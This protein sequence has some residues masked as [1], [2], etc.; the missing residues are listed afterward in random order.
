MRI[1]VLV[2]FFLVSISSFFYLH[3][4]NFD[5]IYEAIDIIYDQQP[6][7][8]L[9]VNAKIDS[10][11]PIIEDQYKKDILVAVSNYIDDKFKKGNYYH[12]EVSRKTLT[13]VRIIDEQSFTDQEAEDSLRQILSNPDLSDIDKDYIEYSLLEAQASI[14][15]NHQN[16]QEA[17]SITIEYFSDNGGYDNDKLEFIARNVDYA[18]FAFFTQLV[19]WVNP[20]G[21]NKIISYRANFFGDESNTA[22]NVV[23][24]KWYDW[25]DCE[26]LYI[27][28]FNIDLI[29]EK[30]CKVVNWD[31]EEQDLADV[32]K[33]DNNL[34]NLSDRWNYYSYVS[35]LDS[36][37]DQMQE[38]KKELWAKILAYDKNYINGYFLM[39]SFYSYKSD[40]ENYAIYFEMMKENYVWDNERKEKVFWITHPNCSQ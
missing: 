19:S 39:L 26:G 35:W 28:D 12:Q 7:K 13:S 8:L 3:A 4:T 23:R 16:F 11:L 10:L 6:E 1:I 27:K 15:L 18:S 31:F 29:D 17:K 9:R 25:L 38:N 14:L 30:L 2:L 33:L 34:Q 22:Y 40:C 21:K 32:E 24:S 20:E 5:K 36:Y 37:R